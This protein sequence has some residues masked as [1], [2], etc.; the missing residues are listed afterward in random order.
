MDR[1]PRPVVAFLLFAGLLLLACDPV[2]VDEPSTTAAPVAASSSAADPSDAVIATDFALG[3]EYMELGLA[4]VYAATG[5]QWAKTRLEAFAWGVN[6]PAP[7]AGGVHDYDWSL[8]DALIGEYQRAG[9]TQIQSYLNPASSWG[10]EN[11]RGAVHG[12]VMP[13]DEFLGDFGDWVAALIERYDGDGRDDMPGLIAPVDRWVIG[14]EWTGFWGSE[15]V[16][17]YIRLLEVAADAARAASET[18]VI[19]TIPFMLIDV[20]HGNEPSG[21]EIATRLVDPPRCC[22]NATAGILAILDRPELFDEVSVHSLGDYTE[23]RPLIDWFRARMAERGY[24]RPV[25]IDDAFPMSGLANFELLPGTG[26]PSVYPVDQQSREDVLSLLVSAAREDRADSEEAIA[27]VRE[28]AAI[29][30]VRK[31]VTA[32]GEGYA[33]IQLGNLEDWM[34]DQGAG[35]REAQ[36]NVIGAATMMGMIDVTHRSGYQV[37]DPRTPGA[38]RP[39][40]HTLALLIEKIGA[41]G[42]DEVEPVGGLTGPRGYRFERGGVPIW[43]LWHEAGLVMPGEPAP[44]I[45]FEILPPDHFSTYLVTAAIT[46][47]GQTEPVTTVGELSADGSLTAQ[48][49]PVPVFVE[50]AR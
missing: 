5:V 33:G 26:W 1:P 32:Y 3:V 8:T 40:Y 2:E 34:L 25:L 41:F 22:R 46:E 14:G 4:E 37:D 49:S 18:V 10:S 36:V 24:D 15:D 47:A 28:Q 45:E 42:Y 21:D 11:V 50:L 7:P 38:P 12:D 44:M 29:G 13:K 35:L 6:E 17:D 39:A 23:L 30:L 9:I 31:A 20:F 48:L 43:V 19:G 27:W 16:E